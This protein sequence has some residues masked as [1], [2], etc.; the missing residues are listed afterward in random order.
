MVTAA[1]GRGIFL[2]LVVLLW[3]GVSGSIYGEQRPILSHAAS[4]SKLPVPDSTAIPPTLLPGSADPT[5]NGLEVDVPGSS[6]AAE[7]QR[8]A[9]PNRDSAFVLAGIIVALIVVFG[10]VLAAC[11]LKRPFRADPVEETAPSADGQSAD[12]LL[13]KKLEYVGEI[14]GRISHDF[15]NQLAGVIGTLTLLRMQYDEGDPRSDQISRAVQGILRARDLTQQ[16]LIFSN[17]QVV[18]RKPQSLRPIVESLI[19]L[20]KPVTSCRFSVMFPHDLWKV[21][22]DGDT[23]SQ[24][25]YNLLL[26][27]T[28]SMPDGGQIQVYAENVTMSGVDY[29]QLSIRDHGS[30]I[31]EANRENIFEPYFTTRP[32][33]QGLGL[34]VAYAVVHRHGGR[35]R[36]ES[37]PGE[38]S[39]FSV[40][41]PASSPRSTG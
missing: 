6:P 35:I 37:D 8:A 28:E 3:T 13:V 15:N 29:V 38:G 4:S 12:D 10:M 27:A 19:E 14:V 32:G 2:G 39:L 40:L 20:L 7:E 25:L 30:G 17:G 16:L 11:R 1:A 21:D 26:N 24:G 23:M 5:V 41:L 18:A 9:Y 31:P 22:I 36:V 34:S 33:K